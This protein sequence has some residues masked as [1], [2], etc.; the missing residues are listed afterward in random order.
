MHVPLTQLEEFKTGSYGLYAHTIIVWEANEVSKWDSVVSYIYRI[1]FELCV[2][3][4]KK[5]ETR[6]FDIWFSQIWERLA[7]H[8]EYC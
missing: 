4:I 1:V 3:K 6:N 5:S 2:T 7:E 8:I